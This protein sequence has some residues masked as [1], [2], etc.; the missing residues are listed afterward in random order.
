MPRI[1][2]VFTL[3]VSVERFLN[4]CSPMELKEVEMA[5]LSPRFQNRMKPPLPPERRK[6]IW[7][8]DRNG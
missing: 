4:A 6:S 3:E 7:P 5:I 2:K 8:R 1:E